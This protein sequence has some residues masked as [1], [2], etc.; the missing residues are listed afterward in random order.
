M[1]THRKTRIRILILIM[2][3]GLVILSLFAYQLGLDNDPGWGRGRLQIFAAGILALLFG[4]FYWVLPMMQKHPLAARFMALFTSSEKEMLSSPPHAN[5][6]SSLSD[7]LL[8]PLG[9]IA[10]WIFL[11]IAT[12]G[13]FDK[14]PSGRDY[15]GLLA[16]AFQHGQTS[17]LVEP[18][19]ELLALENPYDFEQRQ[20]IEYLWDISLYDGKYYLYWGPVPAVLGAIFSALTSKPV[21]DIGLVFVFVIL[22]VLFSWLLVR[23]LKTEF[24]YPGWLYWSTVLVLAFNIPLIWL[25]TRPKYYEVSAAGGQAFMMAGFFFLLLA[26]RADRP[27]KIFLFCAALAFAL[28]GGSRINL[29]PS[30]IFLAAWMLW[31]IYLAYEKRITQSVPAW[32]TVIIPLAAFAILMAWYNHDRFGSVFEFGHRYQL[33][34]ASLTVAF[35]DT[36]SP[37]YILPNLFNY[38]FR[39]PVVEAE[40]PFIT[41]AWLQ[42]DQYP[43][44]F[45]PPDG[46]YGTD[47]V[48]GLLLIVPLV[49]FAVLCVARALWLGLNGDIKFSPSGFAGRFASAVLGSCL[50]Q[51]AVL[52]LFLTSAMRYLADI[53]PAFIVLSMIF[54]GSHG[55]TFA[56]NP[57]QRRVTALFFVFV[58]VISVA[59]GLFIAVTGEGNNFLNQNPQIYYRL[60]ELFT[61]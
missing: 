21:T 3:L 16:Q 9:I 29:L 42:Q 14:W 58:S 12:I 31:Q 18:S 8:L 52:L 24:N 36:L 45:A 19:P 20:G 44:F 48:A 50:I 2:G 57:F 59:A 13:R 61:P 47:P 7:F 37:G 28:A 25:L 6:G 38:F 35:N 54:V 49:G 27:K 53:T 22:S 51:M 60:L 34:G 41:I 1:V 23:T 40:F 15:Y 39:P 17:L 33:T 4:A 32:L 5:G 46:Y 26:F 10:I 43:G 55:S 56:V 30:V 11:W